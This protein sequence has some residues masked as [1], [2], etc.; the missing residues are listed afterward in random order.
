MTMGNHE[1]GFDSMAT[2]EM[3]RDDDEIPMYFV[4]NPQHLNSEYKVPLPA[5][6][7]G[8]HTH[9]IGPTVHLHLDSGY[10][11]PFKNQ[12]DLIKQTG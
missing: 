4:Y 12:S 5:D 3:S 11:I 8:I 1:V 7:S 9:I 2:V 6:R 10:I